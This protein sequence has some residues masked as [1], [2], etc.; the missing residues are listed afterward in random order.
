M[1]TEGD[2]AR[3]I[4]PRSALRARTIV[5]GLVLG[6]PLSILFLWLAIRGVDLGEVWDTLRAANVGFVLVSVPVMLSVLAFQ[7][8][9]WR[10]LLGDDAPLDRRTYIALALFGSGV[11]NVVPGRPGDVV[12]GVWLSRLSGLPVAR[13]LAS[14]AVDRAFDVIT[15]VVILLACL[16]FVPHPSWLRSLA[17]I[18]GLVAAALLVVL[19][20][21][22]WYSHRSAHGRAWLDAPQQK[23]WIKRQAAAVVRGMATMNHA[24]QVA[25]VIG[26]SI[27]VW[28]A[29]T[30]GALL[31]S[32]S[33]G[34]G[35]DPG[36][37]LFV[38]GVIGLGAAIPAAPGMIGTLQWLA[39]TALAV[40]GIGKADALAFSVIL[41]MVVFIPVTFAS[42]A[43]AWWLAIRRPRTPAAPAA[44]GDVPPPKAG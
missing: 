20:F 5:I 27:A 43:I 13:G 1:S 41:Q 37:A 6:I 31:I 4:L 36:Q 8:L 26:W 7:G 38:C 19:V 39:V 24:W 28:A 40:L 33:L 30:A 25:E 14:V 2:D 29:W 23:T 3:D 44:A 34:L 22:W 10:A 15:L 16:P 9:R 42:P 11:S 32:Q 12:R 18:G 35:L 21:A 17:L